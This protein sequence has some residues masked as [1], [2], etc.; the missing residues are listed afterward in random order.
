[1]NELASL[2]PVLFPNPSKGQAQ[3]RWEGE[4]FGYEVL[5]FQG[6]EVFRSNNSSRN[7]AVLPQLKVGIYTV[8]IRSVSGR[9]AVEKWI[10]Y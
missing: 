1:M 5:D 4:Q 6:R 3:I 2:K 9:F 8:I 7:E 10:L